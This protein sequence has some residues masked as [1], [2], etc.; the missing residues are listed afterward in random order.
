MAVSGL[1][2]KHNRI[3]FIIIFYLSHQRMFC[4]IFL[5]HLCPF[6]TYRL[7]SRYGCLELGMNIQLHTDWPQ[8]FRQIVLENAWT[9]GHWPTDL[10]SHFH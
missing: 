3:C 5:F 1:V 6:S 8:L 2:V 10:L 7:H 4:Q 9:V